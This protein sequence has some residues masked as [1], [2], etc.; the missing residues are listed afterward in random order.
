V[1]L[2][3]IRKWPEEEEE[4]EQNARRARDIRRN[5]QEGTSDAR[6]VF[7]RWLSEAIVECRNAHRRCGHSRTTFFPHTKRDRVVTAGIQ[8]ENACMMECRVPRTRL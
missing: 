2:Q 3:D 4:E 6:I 7:A 5:E 1:R 8:H